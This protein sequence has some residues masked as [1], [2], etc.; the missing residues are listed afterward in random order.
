MSP[1][2]VLLISISFVLSKYINQIPRGL[3]RYR[4][5]P[6]YSWLLEMTDF[7]VTLQ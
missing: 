7:W 5:Y 3:A 1:F 6:K 2:H 4:I